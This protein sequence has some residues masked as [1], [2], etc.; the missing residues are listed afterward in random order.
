M[1][2][3]KLRIAGAGR[4][5]GGAVLQAQRRPACPT[6][7][8]GVNTLAAVAVASVAARCR[9]NTRAHLKP[10]VCP[11]SCSPS[12]ALCVGHRPPLGL[13]SP[14]LWSWCDGRRRRRLPQTPHRTPPTTM[15]G[16]L[17]GSGAKKDDK[18]STPSGTGGGT[19][20]ASNPAPARER[21]PSGGFFNL[22]VSNAAGASA[23]PAAP[24]TCARLSRR[25]VHHVAWHG[26]AGGLTLGACAVCGSSGAAGGSLFSGLSTHTTTD[27][28]ATPA[29]SGGMFSYVPSIQRGRC[30]PSRPP[31]T[32]GCVLPR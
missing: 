12:P 15:F 23:S 32:R 20:G 30:P 29:A 16:R 18:P 10:L 25:G 21:K 9:C 14:F 8:N 5:G 3:H 6:P 28:P 24:G 1:C 13:C 26:V 2:C 17:F 22:P 7:E 31:F 11:I 19:S 4:G 27:A